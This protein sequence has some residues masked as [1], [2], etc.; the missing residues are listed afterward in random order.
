[1]YG[2]TMF[3]VIS[4]SLY[5][6]NAISTVATASVAALP[7]LYY[8]AKPNLTAQDLRYYLV[9]TLVVVSVTTFTTTFVIGTIIYKH[10]ILVWPMI[11]SLGELDPE[12]SVFTV[13]FGMTSAMYAMVVNALGVSRKQHNDES[14]TTLRNIGLRF[15]YAASMG[16]MC[17]TIFP[18]T[19]HQLAVIP[20]YA[21]AA[22][23]LI[24]SIPFF[25][26]LQLTDRAPDAGGE[27][28]A[29]RVYQSG[30]V[31]VYSTAAILYPVLWTHWKIGSAM[32][33]TA[34]AASFVLLVSTYNEEIQT[35][36]QIC[37]K[38]RETYISTEEEQE[39]DLG[40]TKVN[41][42]KAQESATHS[43][44]HTPPPAGEQPYVKTL[45]ID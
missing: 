12:S 39:Q 43:Y 9:P 13:G 29:L 32:A 8:N 3:M 10:R 37:V 35:T 34:A 26:M 28:P 18:S 40:P 31:V 33:E 24:G 25:T 1:M 14:L 44:T 17:L 19:P 4:P 36:A 6:A 27:P 30:L 45:D 7:Y 23:F 38:G 2:A 22:T 20:H 21:G 5:L 41:A 15:G 42:T 11:S 16:L